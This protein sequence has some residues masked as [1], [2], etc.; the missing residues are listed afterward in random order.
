M[1]LPFNLIGGDGQIGVDP[2]EIDQLG[3]GDKIQWR[4]SLH[5]DDP[6]RQK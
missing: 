3:E 6:F 2:A 4:Q 5:I 1:K